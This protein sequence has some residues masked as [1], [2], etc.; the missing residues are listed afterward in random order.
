MN[1]NN[2]VT[3]VPEKVIHSHPSCLL[4]K[5]L[6]FFLFAEKVEYSGLKCLQTVKFC[7]TAGKKKEK[8]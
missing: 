7:V 3:S 2:G 8:Q 6:M 1:Q 5:T 4:R